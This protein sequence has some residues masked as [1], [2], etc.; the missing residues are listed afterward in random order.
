MEYQVCFKCHTSWAYGASPPNGTSGQAE[1]DLAVAFNPNNGSGHPVTTGLSNYGGS[2]SP[3]P[4]AASELG[5]PWNTNMGTQTMMCSDC[6]GAD[7]AAPAAQG[8]H[9]SAATFMLVGSNRTWPG[10]FGLSSA[11]WNTGIGTA[12]GLFCA[13]CHPAWN[14]NNVHS[15]GDHSG[16][17]CTRCHILVP[18]G[19]KISRLMATATAGLPARLNGGSVALTAFKKSSSPTGYSESACS[20]NCG[21]HGAISGGETW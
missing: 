13:N 5:A 15:R 18:H 14:A 6:H 16:L 11:S 2:L 4:L 9:A 19:G 10:T 3:K 17:K 7:A 12:A 21:H 1:T 20:T 8:P